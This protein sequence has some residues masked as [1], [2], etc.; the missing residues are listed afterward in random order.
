MIGE[1]TILRPMRDPRRAV[2]AGCVLSMILFGFSGCAGMASMKSDTAAADQYR[3][4]EDLFGDGKYSDAVGAYHAVADRYPD[5]P[6]AA[7]ALYQAAYAQI[8]YENS[9]PDYAA[10]AKDFESLV[11]KYPDSV[12]RSPAQNWLTFLNRLDRLK[13][14]R[15][16]LKN[17]LQKLVDLDMQSEKK[18]R[19]LK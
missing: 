11:Q 12:W 2:G 16:K 3:M 9:N 5:D 6:L 15:E 10:G 7:R 19:E 1:R 8:Y 4:A 18:R 17:D 13:G 14:E